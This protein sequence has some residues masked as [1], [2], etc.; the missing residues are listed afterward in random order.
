M[1]QTEPPNYNLFPSE[2][3]KLAYIGR[4]TRKKPLNAS[5]NSNYPYYKESYGR[6]MAKDIDRM[7]ETKEPILYRYDKHCAPEAGI[8]IATLY[9][10]INQS[11]LFVLENLDKTGRYQEWRDVVEV[12]C[13]K[14]LGVHIGFTRQFKDEAINTPDDLHADFLAASNPHE[15]EPENIPSWK[16]KM[17][18]WLESEDDRPFHMTKLALSEDD[19]RKI[20]MEL[21]TLSGIEFDIKSGS[22]SIVKMPSE[23]LFGTDGIVT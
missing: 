18:D 1:P 16:R 22:V 9:L 21:A 4:L 19:I 2:E 15:V 20:K 10:K 5:A 7:I 11:I 17:N 23:T 6:Q 12:R 3:A 14:G 8:S 13:K